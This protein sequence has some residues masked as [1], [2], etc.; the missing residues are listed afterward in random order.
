MLIID[1]KHADYYVYLAML[2]QLSKPNSVFTLNEPICTSQKEEILFDLCS[3]FEITYFHPFRGHEIS[4]KPHSDSKTMVYISDNDAYF[5]E[6][7][8]TMLN[9]NK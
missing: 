8:D 5:D 7:V 2:L 1:E 4:S 6:L 9:E 3:Q